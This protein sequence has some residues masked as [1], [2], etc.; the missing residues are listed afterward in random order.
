MSGDKRKA[1]RLDHLAATRELMCGCELRERAAIYENEAHMTQRVAELLAAGEV[2]PAE[3]AE[4]ERE[5]ATLRHQG[6]ER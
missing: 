2:L 3:V 6:R 5:V 4:L 1:E